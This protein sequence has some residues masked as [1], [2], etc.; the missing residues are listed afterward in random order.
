[1][2]SCLEHC[3]AQGSRANDI[4]QGNTSMMDALAAWWDAPEDAPASWHLPCTLHSS[5]PG[6][7]N[8]TCET[9]AGLVEFEG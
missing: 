3:A 5:S 6:E 9:T 7:C 4:K 1:M 2:E 8:P